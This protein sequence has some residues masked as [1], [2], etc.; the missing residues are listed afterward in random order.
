M[1]KRINFCILLMLCITSTGNGEIKREAVIQI[2]AIV[3]PMCHIQMQESYRTKTHI[4]LKTV[5]RCNT[6]R[7]LKITENQIPIHH[8][9]QPPAY[10]EK[11][12]YKASRQSS[13]QNAP[14]FLVVQAK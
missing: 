5:E 8:D 14:Y 9:S 6:Q 2:T 12:Q 11:R 1:I 4:V 3:P 13:Q 10:D 7:D